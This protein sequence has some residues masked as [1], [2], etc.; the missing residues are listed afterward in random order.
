MIFR[1]KKSFAHCTCLILRNVHLYFT[2]WFTF[3][4]VQNDSHHALVPSWSNKIG[5]FQWSEIRHGQQVVSVRLVAAVL[6]DVGRGLI[7]YPNRKRVLGWR[8]GGRG[9]GQGWGM[10]CTSQRQADAQLCPVRAENAPKTL[11]LT[12]SG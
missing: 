9:A 5:I 3:N 2:A 10:N 7:C 12:P 1:E 4:L 6:W 11:V 8:G